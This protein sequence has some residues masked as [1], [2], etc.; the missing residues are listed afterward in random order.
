MDFFQWDEKVS[1]SSQKNHRLDTLAIFSRVPFALNHT[2]LKRT[3]SYV[4]C[5]LVSVSGL[6]PL[7]LSF[8]PKSRRIPTQYFKYD[9]DRDDK[10][11][12]MF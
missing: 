9:K 1:K 2:V 7:L 6:A 5:P 4:A 11:Y 10:L 12:L 3:L 8:A